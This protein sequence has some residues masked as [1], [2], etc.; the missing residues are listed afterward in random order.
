MTS[1]PR[2]AAAALVPECDA[3]LATTDGATLRLALHAVVRAQALVAL[4]RHDVAGG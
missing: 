4:V 3:N 2:L 1:T